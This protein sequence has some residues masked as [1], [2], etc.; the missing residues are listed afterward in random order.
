M[1]KKTNKPRRGASLVA[2]RAPAHE[3]LDQTLARAQTLLDAGQMAEAVSLL[4]QNQ[5]RLSQ[6]APFRAALATVYG[7]TGRYQEA[8]VQARMAADLDPRQPAYQ[9]LAALSYQAAGYYTFAQRARRQWLRVVTSGPLLPEMRKLD[10]E[11][12]RN[13]ETMRLL[14]RAPDLKTMEEA[15]YRLDEGRWAMA[16]QDWNEALRASRAAAALAP[17][18]PPPHNNIAGALFYLGRY[19]EAIAEL[20][21]VLH[22]Y[23]PDN[24]HALASL[25]RFSAAIGD[26]TA[27][28]A[29]A[30]QLAAQP[31][32]ESLEEAVKQIEGLAIVDRDSAILALAREAKRRFEA[33]PA[34]IYTHWGIAEANAGRRCEA[35]ARLRQAQTAGDASP[36]L[37]S[38]LEALERRQP[39]PGI[40][41][42][43]PQTHYTELS[44]LA[45]MELAGKQLARDE[46]RGE[47]DTAAWDD[48]LR[49]HPQIP[50]VARRML[51]E[52]EGLV[53]AMAQLLAGVRTPE[54]IETLRQ[55]MRGQQGTDQDRF[56]VMRIMQQNQI[57][58]PDTR[59]DIYANGELQNMQSTLQEISDENVPDYTPEVWEAYHDALTA[60]RDGRLDEAER[61]YERMLRLEPNAKEAYNN[62]AGIYLARG[63]Q[64][65]ADA[66]IDRSLA[67]DPLYPFPITMRALQAL[68]RGDIVKAKEWLAPLHTITRWN[69]MGMVV[70]QKTMAKV[71]LQEDRFKE[72]KTHL[73]LA[74]KLNPEDA[75]AAD[76]LKPLEGLGPLLEMGDWF[77][78]HDEQSRNRRLRRRLPA[79]PAL[80]DCLANLSQGDLKGI[81]G[82][83][84]LSPLSGIRVAELR[85]R[86]ASWLAEPAR[87]A[88]TIAGLNDQERRALRNL[89]SR[90]GVMP[91]A[92]FTQ[93]H[94]EET[95]RPFLEFHAGT[96][97][98]VPGRLRA[99]GL[100]FE[101]TA[102]DQVIVAIPRE[103][104]PLVAAEL[105]RWP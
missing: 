97:T 3:H 4:E 32:P 22:N 57:L 44:S 73:E 17:N 53:E 54:A 26:L 46:E 20:R 87:M 70:Y 28:N 96:M 82:V 5:G 104:R 102:G 40:A 34:S 36:L 52:C 13:T 6:F 50:V 100:L 71:A 90:G 33:L 89:L 58:P 15:G 55:F 23:D 98:S 7:Q 27:A 80:A 83:L 95:E 48:L 94:G 78:D 68:N 1:T 37:R 60:H 76:L 81:G 103:L 63:D 2:R 12:R 84:G 79:D 16:R 9:L 49:R 45:V 61:H 92:A 38:T 105:A 59:V 93:T 64:A 29:Y 11:Y 10:E 42:R 35:L 66:A 30:D 14:Y 18:W 24:I 65:A 74:L 41:A 21:E 43:F 62:L 47:R 85:Q 75:E 99:R 69:P 19:A 77:R 91:R 56:A 88:E 86:F 101:G 8:A 72:A 51:Y 25:V 39:G 31:L 67:I